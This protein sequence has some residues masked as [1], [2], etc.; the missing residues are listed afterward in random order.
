MPTQAISNDPMLPLMLA[1]SL[2]GAVVT[3]LVTPKGKQKHAGP[4][5]LIMSLPPL[6]M[7]L[8][9]LCTFPRT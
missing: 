1:A 8:I 4:I 2:A 6:V 5:A 9:V 7:S 3:L